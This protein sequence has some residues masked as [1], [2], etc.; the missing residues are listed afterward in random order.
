MVTNIL[1]WSIVLWGYLVIFL[2]SINVTLWL[3]YFL[4]KAFK[5]LRNPLF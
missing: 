4:F 2:L 1:A 5:R 3:F